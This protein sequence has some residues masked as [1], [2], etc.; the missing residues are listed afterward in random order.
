MENDLLRTNFYPG[1]RN[2]QL[3]YIN[4]QKKIN[5][6][7]PLPMTV[8]MPSGPLSNGDKREKQYQYTIV[9][10]D[11]RMRYY[12]QPTPVGVPN[13]NN[14]P[15][16]V[17]SNIKEKNLAILKNTASLDVGNNFYFEGVVYNKDFLSI[18]TKTFT[19]AITAITQNTENLILTSVGHGI[20]TLF[21]ASNP[22]QIQ[23]F[24]LDTAPDINGEIFTGYVFDA[25]T[26][27][28]NIG[29]LTITGATGYF[30]T[31]ILQ[32]SIPGHG[33]LTGETVI[34]KEY[35][36]I[37]ETTLPNNPIDTL[38]GTQ[39]LNINY[40]GHNL[41]VGELLKIS[42]ATAPYVGNFVYS[43]AA[44]NQYLIITVP[45]HGMTIGQVYKIN[46]EFIDYNITVPSA[47][48]EWISAE[49]TSIFVQPTK[50]TI[51]T[52]TPHRLD[53][54]D[55]I[56]F[57]QLKSN[58]DVNQNYQFEVIT[59]VDPTTFEISKDAL[60]PINGFETESDKF[61]GEVIDP[62]CTFYSRMI[63]LN[64]ANH[65]FD[66]GEV[67]LLE[68]NGNRQNFDYLRKVDA[69]NIKLY[70][71]TEVPPIPELY[72]EYDVKLTKA[73][74]ND[75]LTMSNINNKEY[76]V[77]P[78]DA[79]N[80]QI[81]IDY[82][83][84]FT[85][86]FS[87][88]SIITNL[89]LDGYLNSVYTVK[90]VI[91]A[92]NINVENTYL[93]NY[94]LN[95]VGVGGANVKVNVN[96]G[97]SSNE[98]YACKVNVIDPNTIIST[99]QDK[100]FDY[101]I[102]KQFDFVMEYPRLDGYTIN[103]LNNQL[104][105]VRKKVGDQIY[106]LIPNSSFTINI[107]I[108]GSNVIVFRKDTTAQVNYENPNYYKVRLPRPFTFVK[109]VDMIST[110]FYMNSYV[111]YEGINDTFVFT[112]TSVNASNEGYS[113]SFT[114]TVTPGTYTYTQLEDYITTEMNRLFY[115]VW[116]P[117]KFITNYDDVIAQLRF[118]ASIDSSNGI[119]KI[120]AYT[121]YTVNDPFLVEKQLIRLDFDLEDF[122]FFPE[123][124]YSIIIENASITGIPSEQI[125][126]TH[127]LY[128]YSDSQ[129]T[130]YYIKFQNTQNLGA[131]NVGGNNV[132]I[133]VPFY[134]MLFGQPDNSYFEQMSLDFS[135]SNLGKLLGFD[136]SVYGEFTNPATD[137][138]ADSFYKYTSTAATPEKYVILTIPQLNFNNEDPFA[139]IRFNYII[140]DNFVSGVKNFGG[141]LKD[142]LIELTLIF[143][144]YQGNPFDFNYTEH[145]LT[146]LFT[147]ELDLLERTNES[148]KRGT[149][150]TT[151]QSPAY[152]YTS[153]QL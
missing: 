119:T 102:L 144:D 108:G 145:S 15:I 48:I 11:S 43:F 85:Q 116:T 89:T 127:R 99:I 68:Y 25:N 113:R 59:I 81:V 58:P 93:P 142:Q 70:L 69:N 96:G 137:S 109:Q 107:A 97:L 63:I 32:Q 130:Y 94:T 62:E 147:E 7:A 44:N 61:F 82:P 67:P 52:A 2:E 53:L 118:I 111:I 117:Y 121:R 37:P 123:R 35:Q 91:D 148:S 30:K 87:M 104:F 112:I 26:I 23:M 60:I 125:N 140:E 128:K 66:S 12:T 122:T 126:T 77:E 57:Y 45:G 41:L 105:T 10:I 120:S 50:V 153:S 134:S 17:G 76:F 18:P 146:L 73:R 143:T 92:N 22:F 65:Q 110:E 149:I 72:F 151:A 90:T 42:G 88:S 24:Y 71:T 47:S 79:N 36:G 115:E 106:F 51:T 1:N 131:L 19:G 16:T 136:N 3:E 98:T 5:P 31:N 46:L 29:V 124:E 75:N 14:N 40:P 129:Q 4:R 139:K 27:Y 33:L 86:S 100:L 152:S 135:G 49:P 114:L 20:P 39:E 74:I 83:Y 28:V 6:L 54:G 64:Y 84:S 9:N 101:Q 55:K 132:N 38:A 103:N 78:L 8:S 150:I 133:Y 138:G 56:F 13:A 141:V 21:D 95:L 80:F 34:E